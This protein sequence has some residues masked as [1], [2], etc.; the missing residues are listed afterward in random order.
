MSWIIKIDDIAKKKLRKLD[1]QS[2]KAIT[3]YLYKRI[4]KL[5]HPKQSGKVLVGNDYK[6]LWRYRVDK[7]RIICNIKENELIVLVVKI[8]KRDIVYDEE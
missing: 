8:A 7:F 4:A 1:H 5:E 3:T 2:Q 6:G